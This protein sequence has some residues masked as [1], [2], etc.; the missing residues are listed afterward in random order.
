[1]FDVALIHFHT[2]QI[3]KTDFLKTAKKKKIINKDFILFNSY[4]DVYML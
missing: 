2:K 4:A 3:I 1:M